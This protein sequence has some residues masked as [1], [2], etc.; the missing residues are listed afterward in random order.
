MIQPYW[1]SKDHW[2][3]GG[4]LFVV[5]ALTLAMVHI[6]VLFNQ[7]NNAFFGALQDKNQAA[8]LYQLLRVSWLIALFILFAV[9]QLYLN[10]MLEICWRRCLT[11]R[12]L[13]ARSADD[14]YSRSQHMAGE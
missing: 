13:R 10:Q 6:S 5:V 9:Y 7:W 2:V 4:L 8:F 3:A 11:E 12:Y 1:F 14:A